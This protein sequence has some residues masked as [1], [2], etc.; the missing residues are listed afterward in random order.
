MWEIFSKGETPYSE[1]NME[2][3]DFYNIL[4][5]GIGVTKY[6]ALLSQSQNMDIFFSI[7]PQH[8][9][10]RFVFLEN[11]INVLACHLSCP[12][13]SQYVSVMILEKKTMR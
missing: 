3:D 5:E 13:I 12:T 6:R 9:Y 1:V 10:V 7:L 2:C 8:Y 4:L 11:A